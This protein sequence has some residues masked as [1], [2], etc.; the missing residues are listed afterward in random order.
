MLLCEHVRPVLQQL[1]GNLSSCFPLASVCCLSVQ[2]YVWPC[3]HVQ[4]QI[5]SHGRA[6]HIPAA[7]HLQP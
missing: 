5:L 4:L 7:I 6:G 3:R 1:R 2:M